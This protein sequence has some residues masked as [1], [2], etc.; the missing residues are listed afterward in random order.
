MSRIAY[1]MGKAKSLPKIVGRVHKKTKTPHIAIIIVGIVT[2]LFASIGEIGSVASMANFIIFIIFI[3][4]NLALIRL[5]Y[6]MPKE[7]RGFKI[8]GNIGRFAVVPFVGILI[9]LF[10]ITNINPTFMI[11]GIGL[12]ILGFIAEWYFHKK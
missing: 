1:G 10:L 11:Y 6:T 9:S 12:I 8:P 4:I 5:R 3:V 7:K 2:I